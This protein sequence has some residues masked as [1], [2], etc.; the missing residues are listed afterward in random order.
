MSR[1]EQMAE[2]TGSTDDY[3]EMWRQLRENIEQGTQIRSRGSLVAAMDRLDSKH[4]SALMG[5]FDD[6]A[7][8]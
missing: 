6:T 4:S 5:A 3:R 7:G 2:F 1:R 8:N